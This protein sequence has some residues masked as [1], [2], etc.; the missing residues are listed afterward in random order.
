M[1]S[2]QSFWPVSHRDDDFWVCMS[3]LTEVFY[4]KVPMPDCPSCHGVSTYEG[5]T[6]EAIRDWGTEELIAKAIAAEEAAA[7]VQPAAEPAASVEAAD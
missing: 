1:A 7:S 6:L 4:R 3:C 5:F 2:M